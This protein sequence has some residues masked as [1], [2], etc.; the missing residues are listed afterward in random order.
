MERSR[1]VGGVDAEEGMPHA[2]PPQLGALRGIERLPMPRPRHARRTKSSPMYAPVGVSVA[3]MPPTTFCSV[4]R[5]Q[6]QAEI[7]ALVD[8]A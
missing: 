8:E 3:S 4:A 1:V 2:A 6:P 7:R 5:D